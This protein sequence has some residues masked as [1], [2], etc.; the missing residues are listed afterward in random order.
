M[1]I[2]L[3]KDGPPFLLL[4]LLLLLLVLLLL[5]LKRVSLDHTLRCCYFYQDSKLHLL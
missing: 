2:H 4:L 1:A 3:S 5:L